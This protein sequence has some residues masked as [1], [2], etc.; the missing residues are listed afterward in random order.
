V[1]LLMCAIA[2]AILVRALI[3]LH[4]RESILARAIGD[5]RK[6]WLSIAMYA[7]GIA[8]SFWRPWVGSAAYVIVAMIW[9]IPDRR[10]ENTIHRDEHSRIGSEPKLAASHS[11][12]ESGTP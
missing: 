7:A 3:G 9:L 12:G 6:G 2:Y 8:L 10:I 1:V 5:D 4:G 11:N